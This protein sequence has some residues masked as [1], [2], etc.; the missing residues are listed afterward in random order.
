MDEIILQMKSIT[1]TFPG[2][3]ALDNVNLKVKKREIHSL[4]GE[5]GAGKSTLMKVLSGVHPYGTYEGDIIY[6]GEV[7]KF[8]EIRDSEKKGIVI[9][10]QELAL[11]PY[12]SIAENIF[13]GNEQQNR[14]VIDWNKTYHKTEQLLKRV[15]L[16][17]N[18]NT[19]V[20][21]IGVG[22]QQLVEIAK[23]LSKKVEL[24]ILDEPT[25]ALNE[26]ES[27]NLLNL[28]LDL[29][30]EG[31]SSILISHKLNEVSAVADQ[32][33]ILRDGSTIE[34]I[35]KETN[36][37]D[38]NRIIR[39]MVGRD[40]VDR[41]PKRNHQVGDVIFEVKDWVV[42]DP[43]STERKVIDGVNFNVRAGEVIGLAGLMGSGRT[44]LAMS[45]FGRSFGTKISG[46]VYKNGKKIDLKTIEQAVKNGVAYVTED[47]KQYGL[48][49][50]DD[51]CRNISLSSLEKISHLGKVNENQE[52]QIA[53]EY[54]LKMNIKSPS[55]FQK[56]E[57]L[58]GGNQQKVVLSKWILTNPD[59]LILD[60]PTRG[61]D[62]GAKYE[63]YL[64][65]NELVAQGKSVIIISS[66]L[67]EVLG[68]SDRVYVMNEGKIVGELQGEQ[69]TQ[70]SV[71]TCIMGS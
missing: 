15:G 50:I 25:A 44:E 12:L 45:L 5:N 49:L 30:E 46:E 52:K 70:E 19:L 57:N 63:I 48:V 10:H 67:P 4:C 38:E 71:M 7:C 59:V 33:T 53:E 26:V 51:I 37:I 6:K 29:K 56:T 34:T 61:I 54:R 31:I 65:I 40:I 17:E 2:V 21:D 58:S 9:I 69:A 14:G 55:I 3:K 22:K 11:I 36:M 16:D 60:E 28:L 18:P 47:R 39:G 20:C 35:I 42:Y 43:M 13:L 41:F 8:K 24:L 68:M 62:V 27:E 64:I 23:A 1:K 32:I 66:E